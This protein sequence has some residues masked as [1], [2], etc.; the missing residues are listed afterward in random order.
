MRNHGRDAYSVYAKTGTRSQQVSNY[1]SWGQ[2][3]RK[4][5]ECC[6]RKARIVCEQRFISLNRL[7]NPLVKALL[8]CVVRFPVSFRWLN[9]N[10]SFTC[11]RCRHLLKRWRDY[12]GPRSTKSAQVRAHTATVGLYP[13]VSFCSVVQEIMPAPHSFLLSGLGLP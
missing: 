8:E 1:T 6:E 11:V 7:M 9:A 3:T 5:S 13:F 4:A 12:W 2:R 10:F